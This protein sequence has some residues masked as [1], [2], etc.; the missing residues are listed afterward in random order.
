MVV[1]RITVPWFRIEWSGS[2][3]QRE[4]CALVPPAAS[5]FSTIVK[6]AFS[7]A[8]RPPASCVA[9]SSAPHACCSA[10][11]AARPMTLS[12]SECCLTVTYTHTHTNGSQGRECIRVHMRAWAAGE[13]L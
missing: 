3:V 13:L 10:H 7:A 9:R 12:H 1:L 5:S 8:A 2:R 4:H 11:Y 6:P